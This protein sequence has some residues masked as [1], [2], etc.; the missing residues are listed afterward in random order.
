MADKL[1]MNPPG[2]LMMQSKK[3]SYIYT[4]KS[5]PEKINYPL[6]RKFILGVIII[7]VPILGLLFAWIGLRLS[8]QSR[9]ETLEKTM[10][11]A[12]QIILTRHQD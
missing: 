9:Q 8:D 4:T 11:I 2:R 3:D 12:D 7:I 1:K 10:V 5:P 6:K